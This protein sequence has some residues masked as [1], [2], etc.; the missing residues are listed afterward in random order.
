MISAIL[1]EIKQKKPNQTT[2]FI[3][4]KIFAKY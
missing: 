2:I 4:L 3:Y 1:F